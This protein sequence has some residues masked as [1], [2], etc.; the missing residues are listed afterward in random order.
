MNN[1]N[2]RL[3]A[4]AISA[5]AV[6]SLSTTAAMA[7]PGNPYTIGGVSQENASNKA[8][9]NPSASVQLSIHKILGAPTG[10]VANGTEQQVAGTPL[11][12]V[13]FDVYQVQGVDLTTNTGWAAATALQAYAISPADIANGY[14]TVDGTRYTL[15]KQPS[16]TTNA[17]GT[18]TFT[19]PN[20]VGFYLVNENLAASGTVTNGTTGATVDKSTITGSKPFFVT[21][22]MTNPGDT[23]RWMYD[24]NVYPKNQSDTI[25]KAVEDKGTV[26]SEN[27]NVGAHEVTYTL[28]SDIT[29]GLTG[30]QMARYEVRDQ[31]DSRLTYVSTAV[32]IDTDGNGSADRVLAEGT[33]YTLANVAEAGATGTKVVVVMTASGLEKLAAANTA[34]ASAKVVTTIKATVDEEGTNGLIPNKA[35]FIPNQGWA[36]QNPGSDIPSPEVKSYYGDVVVT[37]VDTKTRA[38]LAG[39]DF[40]IYVDP[41]PGDG[42]CSAS[43]VAG[44]PVRTVTSNDSGVA[45]FTGLQ[46]SNWYNNAEQTALLS[47]C[48]V[49]T[50]APT[51]YNLDAEP[52]YVTIDYKTGTASQAPRVAVEV[53]DEASNLGNSLPLTGGRGVAALSTLGL[54]LVGGGVAYYAVSA[55]RKDRESA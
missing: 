31:L 23:A 2:K 9:V 50:K 22:P 43:D 8:L 30:P 18:A 12:G 4:V 13:V 40:A 51:G 17:T 29:D 15:A 26:T 27:G 20:G 3:A 6:G 35:S 39:A 24:V 55:R 49:E 42:Q 38:T 41:T 45:T 46:A 52:H 5:L 36:D 16:V 34:N 14:V 48:L 11:Q 54:V 21:L 28:T 1:I 10:G 37:K 32:G 44:T 19:K 47:Y 7:D 53:Q 33:D 25:A